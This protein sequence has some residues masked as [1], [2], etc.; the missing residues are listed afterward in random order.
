[1]DADYKFIYYD[2]GSYGSE[3]DST[4][5]RKSGLGRRFEKPMLSWEQDGL[6]LPFDDRIE[7]TQ[8]SVPHVF[9]G[10]QA[11]KLQRHLM[12]PYRREGANISQR[13]FNY[14]LCRTRRLA[15]NGFGTL[16]ARWRVL[17]GRIDLKLDTV[18]SVVRA[19]ICLH[20]MIMT[21]DSADRTES[22]YLTPNFVDDEDEDGTVILGGWRNEIGD[23][24]HSAVAGD[25]AYADPLDDLDEE[26]EN[27]A[28]YRRRFKNYFF[29]EDGQL[30]WQVER[31]QSCRY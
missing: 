11:F 12:T 8:I 6:E 27:G 3:S 17:D 24:L 13:H 21:M 19:C 2:I 14:R 10:D 31:V 25:H 4:V 16:V 23:G 9:V 30:Q 20:N 7:N 29:S 22:K 1:M 28:K 26:N 15:E 5:F 18:I